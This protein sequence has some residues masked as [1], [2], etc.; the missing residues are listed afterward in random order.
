MWKKD[1]IEAGFPSHTLAGN[2]YYVLDNGG[3]LYAFDASDGKQ[4]WRKKVDTIAKASLVYADGKIYVPKANGRFT[5]VKPEDT[6]NTLDPLSAITLI[7]SGLGAEAGNPCTVTAPVFDGR[8]RY[9]D[10]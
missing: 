5:V 6:K 9:S 7:F 4:Y 3:G 8:R 1:G 10:E 2:R